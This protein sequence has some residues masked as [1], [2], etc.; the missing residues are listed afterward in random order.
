MAGLT[1]SGINVHFRWVTLGVTD[2]TIIQSIVLRFQFYLSELVH[3]G[4]AIIHIFVQCLNRRGML[5]VRT[6]DRRLHVLRHAM[7]M[8]DFCHVAYAFAPEDKA[9]FSLAASHNPDANLNPLCVA[10]PSAYS[11]LTSSSVRFLAAH[12]RN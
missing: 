5:V 3:L 6:H 7:N 10:L 2:Q 9:S 4:Q 8:S 11:K 1:K 12:A